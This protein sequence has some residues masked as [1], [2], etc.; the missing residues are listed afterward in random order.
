MI[1]R[2]VSG[3]IYTHRLSVV[4]YFFYAKYLPFLLAILL[5]FTACSEQSRKG[6]VLRFNLYSDPPTLDS[7]QAIDSTS[8]NVLLNL[9]EGLTRVGPDNMPHPAIAE[10][11][12]I[13]EDKLTYTFTLRESFWTNGDAVTSGDFLYAWQKI[14]DPEFPST[15]AYK[16]YVIKNGAKVKE[17]ILPKEE[18][19]ITAP[20]AKTLVVTLE[21]PTPYFLE[22]TSFPTYFPVNKKIDEQFDGW[23]AEAGPSFVSN[24]PFMLKSWNHESDLSFV[25]NPSYWDAATVNLEGIDFVMVDDTMTEFYMFEM[26]ELDWAGSPLSNLPSEMLPALQKEGK[27]NSYS[28]V[29]TYYYKLNTEHPP[30]QNKKIRQALGLA[31]D[32]RAIVKH[33]LQANQLP[34][35]ALVPPLLNW[36]PSTNYFTNADH[37]KAKVLFEEGLEEQG[38]N[39]SALP[40]L[41]LSFNSN[42]EHQKIAQ[43]IQQQWQELLGIRVDLENCDWKSYLSK[44]NKQDYH[45]ARTAWVG[46]YN[47]PISFLEPYKYK[48]NPHTGGNN[49]TGWENPEFTAL[50]DASDREI[51]PEKRTELLR[52]AE[53]LIIE[54]MPVIP[55]FYIVF[56]Y[57]C[58]PYVKDVYLSSLGV[59]DFKWA[60][61]EH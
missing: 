56:C 28:T 33:I 8:I 20:D 60:K 48:D 47:D 53:E 4:K 43:A 12:H 1:G 27:L 16:L 7:R 42:R 5:I 35:T 40:A 11:I 51:V 10:E 13:S 32:R 45:I 55:I 58:K 34:A 49:E 23:S 36:R 17:G 59:I 6:Q 2:I 57:L 50:L 31:I 37:E 30:L 18:L 41:V 52:Q 54:E 21:H 61:C 29:G 19:G 44:V 15:L 38:L 9:F 3:K 24:G 26:G 46:D 25:K 22:L 39:R 14:L